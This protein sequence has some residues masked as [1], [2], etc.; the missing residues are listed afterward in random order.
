MKLSTSIVV[1]VLT[2]GVAFFAYSN[3]GDETPEPFQAN[4]IDSIPTP[5]PEIPE[6]PLAKTPTPKVEVTSTQG[7]NE[8]LTSILDGY[9]E[10]QSDFDRLEPQ[11]TAT[12]AGN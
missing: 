11:E 3:H 4:I 6:S 5:E 1:V 9:D 10:I 2:L 12:E 7:L 8:E